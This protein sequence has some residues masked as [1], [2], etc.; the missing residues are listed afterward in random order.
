VGD[1]PE[2]DYKGFSQKKESERAKWHQ[3]KDPL[4]NDAQGDRDIRC[5]KGGTTVKAT[6][7]EE[8]QSDQE[9]AKRE[10]SQWDRTQEE[11]EAS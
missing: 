4:G 2:T 6:K 11:Q 10:Q 5:A 9:E 7:E 3:E 1:Q 8:E